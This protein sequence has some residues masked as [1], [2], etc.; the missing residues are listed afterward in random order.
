MKYFNLD[1]LLKKQKKEDEKNSEEVD[2]NNESN[3]LR[4][5]SLVLKSLFCHLKA[6][7][8]QYPFFL[9]FFFFFHL[10]LLVGG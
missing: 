3:P 7:Y 10:F 2:H 4:V 5:R 9:S 6:M 8:S 1:F